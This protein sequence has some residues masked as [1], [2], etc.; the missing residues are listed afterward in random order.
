MSML[1]WVA[2]RNESSSLAMPVRCIAVVNPTP[3][4]P[5]STRLARVPATATDV[6]T[7]TP[8]VRYSAANMI[9][10]AP[11][12]ATSS[13]DEPLRIAGMTNVNSTAKLMPSPAREAAPRKRP[14]A[15]MS[16]PVRTSNQIIGVER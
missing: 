16:A 11:T 7:L 3:R 9:A 14:K 15:R 5:V 12:M 1:P 4:A 13:G 6:C 2:D 8:C 10:E